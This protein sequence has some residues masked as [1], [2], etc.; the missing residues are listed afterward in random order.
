MRAYMSSG[1]SFLHYIWHIIFKVVTLKIDQITNSQ[2]AFKIY[3]IEY[4]L[5]WSR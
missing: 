4:T 5:N 1:D 2:I 3:H